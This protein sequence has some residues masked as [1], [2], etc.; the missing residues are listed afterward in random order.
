MAVHIKLTNP[1]FAVEPEIC[2]GDSSGPTDHAVRWMLIRGP[3]IVLATV[4][5][6]PTGQ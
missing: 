3:R 2:T 1:V 6:S 4:H 5:R